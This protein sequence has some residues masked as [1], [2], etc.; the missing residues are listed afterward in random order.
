MGSQLSDSD[1]AL[2]VGIGLSNFGHKAAQEARAAAGDLARA[3]RDAAREASGSFR[4]VARE[5]SGSFRDV[6]RDARRAVTVVAVA[7]VLVTLILSGERLASQWLSRS[8]SG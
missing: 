8:C 1:V 4:D 6:A 2:F 7:T 5:A 3:F